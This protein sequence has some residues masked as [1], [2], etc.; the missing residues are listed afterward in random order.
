M[1]TE[2]KK[3]S[4]AK[5]I[6]LSISVALHA[7][8]IYYLGKMA[9][10]YA[11]PHGD[12]TSYEMDFSKGS[13][14]Q[15]T[16]VDV[17]DSEPTPAPP[18]VPAPKKEAPP[19]V[20]N[21]PKAEKPAQTL[22]VKESTEVPAQDMQGVVPVPTEIPED[23]HKELME[24]PEQAAQAE[25]EP[26]GEETLPD[27]PPEVIPT[28]VVAAEPPSAQE[29]PAKQAVEG[30]GGGN[31]TTD[32][33]GTPTGIQS[34]TVLAPFGTNRPISYPT[35]ARF[36]KLEGVTVVHYAVSAEG[37]VTDVKVV[38]SSGHAIL[39]NQAVE[40]IKD[41]KFKS[42]GK[43]GI[44]ERPIRYSL[45]GDAKEAPSQLRRLKNTP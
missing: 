12:V 10:D 26:Q 3:M 18:V 29:L 8:L 41:W 23:V 37:L 32:A 17:I 38:Q 28:P 13:Q 44:Y 4:T 1:G 20:A 45:R 24:E 7:G 39:D 5:V 43:A 14:I 21:T 15:T 42:T 2:K 30:D 11:L 22:P 25:P 16:Q 36:R 6:A 33:Y 27:N 19:E 40:T 9:I 31:V 34:D 35:L